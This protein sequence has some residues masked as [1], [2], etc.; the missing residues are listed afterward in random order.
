MLG[1]LPP[2]MAD[3]YASHNSSKVSPVMNLLLSDFGFTRL[4][5]FSLK[6]VIWDRNSGLIF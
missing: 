4:K 6:F 1:K 3:V 2:F 5:I